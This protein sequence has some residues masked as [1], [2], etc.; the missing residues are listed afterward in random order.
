MEA[1]QATAN[2]WVLVAEDQPVA[3]SA[4]SGR[5]P[6][7]VQIGGVWTP[8]ELRGKGYAK[9][10]VAGSLLEVR[11]QG[12]H[13]AILFTSPENLAAQAAYRGIGF[14]PT[15]EKFGLVLFKQD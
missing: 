9:C 3:Y 10:V 14:H 12:V 8:P 7:V 4:F 6:D 1:H 5:L 2:H 15:G 11:S 13:R